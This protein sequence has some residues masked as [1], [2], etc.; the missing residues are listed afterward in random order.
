MPRG[1]LRAP[2]ATSERFERLLERKRDLMPVP[3]ARQTCSH[4][5]AA[6][7]FHS[8]ARKAQRARPFQGWVI[9]VRAKTVTC[10]AFTAPGAQDRDAALLGLCRTTCGHNPPL[11]QRELLT[12]CLV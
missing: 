5:L 1:N 2:A 4:G 11:T 8:K 3:S 6:V 10:L 9:I 12:A 7:E